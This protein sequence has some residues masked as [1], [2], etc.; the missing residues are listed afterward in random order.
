M[1]TKLAYLTFRGWPLDKLESYL[2][3]LTLPV[4]SDKLASEENVSKVLEFAAASQ[5]YVDVSSR[6]PELTNQAM[7]YAISGQRWFDC[8]GANEVAPTPF[9]DLQPVMTG[10]MFEYVLAR[11]P[12]HKHILTSMSRDEP[13]ARN[14]SGGSFKSNR[15]AVELAAAAERS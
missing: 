6:L 12:H 4:S 7:D 11:A 10:R 8:M 9:G 13:G 2:A 1:A 5:L 3:S 14:W 15:I